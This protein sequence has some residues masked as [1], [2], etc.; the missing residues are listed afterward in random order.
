MLQVKENLELTNKIVV[1][2]INGMLRGCEFTLASGRTLFIVSD[3]NTIR[4][5]HQGTLLPDST[6]YI[7]AKGNDVNFEI[8]VPDQADQQVIL[9]ELKEKETP[10]R[11]IVS[12]EII[13]IGGQRICWRPE[14]VPFSD[15][16][17]AYTTDE[18]IP[19]FGPQDDEP[20]RF[21][22]TWWKGAMV[23]GIVGCLSFA[24]Y[25]YLTETQRQ[26]NSV[27]AFLESGIGNYHIVYGSDKKIYALALTDIAA[28][29]ALQ[30]IVRTPQSYQMQV[31]TLKAEEQRISKWIGS[32]WPQVKFH[33]VILDDPKKPVLQISAERTR[34]SEPEKKR[35]INAL[36][37]SI[38]YSTSVVIENLA[39][40]KVKN[41][42]IEGLK[43]MALLFTEIDNGS[44]TTFVIRGAIEDGE[45][46]RLKNFIT[47]YYQTWGGEY[48]QFALE[49]KNDWLKGKSYK[50]GAQGY[51]KLA[52]GHWYFPRNIQKDL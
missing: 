46:E 21:G 5:Q 51:V 48:I 47:K 29:W 4:Q 44:S 10:E 13:S 20:R 26:I 2:L 23:L 42:A 28:Q 11:I 14:A 15:E 8:L 32:N 39:D 41:L 7:P 35:L 19:S 16:V 43:K 40:V 24:G 30:T 9:R 18:V 49:L 37:E 12:N 34:L 1:R 17:L 36:S 31:L 25:T 6:I 45:L 22:S 3:D 52:P 27:S 33:R 38:P 50:Y